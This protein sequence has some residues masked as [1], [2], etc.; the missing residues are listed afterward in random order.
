MRLAQSLASSLLEVTHDL[1]VCAILLGGD[2]VKIVH[3]SRFRA[4]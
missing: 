1:G 4:L 3:V 2:I